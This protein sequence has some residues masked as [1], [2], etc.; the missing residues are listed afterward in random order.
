[1]Q[2]CEVRKTLASFLCSPK[3]VCGNQNSKYTLILLTILFCKIWNNMVAA[4]NE[5][6]PESS[7]Y[8]TTELGT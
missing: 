1:M 7:N 2:A 3:V 4:Q 8:L 5:F 6:P